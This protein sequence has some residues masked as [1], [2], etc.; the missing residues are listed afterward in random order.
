MPIS[1]LKTRQ[2]KPLYWLIALSIPVLFFV[3]IELGLRIVDYG[4]D[5]PLFIANPANTEYILP[6]PDIVRRYF[7]DNSP[8]PSVTMEANFLLKEKP[9]N[10]YRV[11]VQG[12]S[13]AAGFPYGL[14]ASLAGMLDNRLKSTLPYHYVEVVNT[15][16]SAV[17][18]YTVLDLADEIIAQQPDAVLIY[19]GHNE[20]LGIMG[21]GSNYTAA[22]SQAS[23]LL[24]LKLKELRLF[25]LMQNTYSYFQQPKAT[26]KTNF[27]DSRTFMAKVAKHK[28]IPINS[29]MFEAG[30][31]QFDTNLRLLL[32][33]YAAANVPVYL[34][35]IASNLKDQA[36]FASPDL[37]DDF[38]RNLSL[39]DQLI[40]AK[41]E[42]KI[43]AQ[44]SKMSQ[45]KS[46]NN[47]ALAQFELANRYYL[48]GN[49]SSAYYHYNQ[50]KELDLLRFRAPE[51]INNIIRKYA[52]SQQNVTLVDVVERLAKSSKHGLIGNNL[53]LEHL[54]PNVQ[55]YFLLADT[56]YNAI[57]QHSKLL[58]WNT[59]RIEKAWQNR[60]II[61][62]E[63]YNGFAKILQLM[64][65]FPFTDTPKNLTLPQPQ[66]W[67]QSLGK[68][69]FL[70]QI[71]W[72][73]MMKRALKGYQQE[74]NAEMVLKSTQLLADAMPHDP[75][76]NQMIG[77]L[78]RNKRQPHLSIH[79]YLRAHKVN[80][81]SKILARSLI[82]AYQANKQ[83]ELA[84][85]WQLQLDKLE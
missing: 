14:G 85:Q 75:I 80:P 41:Q 65:D 51:A 1:P 47:N 20:Y 44:L 81:D 36:P 29:N 72:V 26:E 54:H 2:N 35:T 66:D 70:K 46:L 34:A 57:K 13:T 38:S 55:G 59:V 11:F 42:D 73:T 15:A 50:A 83:P 68:E 22:S 25:Q 77:N 52:K 16:L 78:F 32:D 37:S 5:L 61:P 10:G 7:S 33:K 17:N 9:K 63:E 48:M 79:Y 84:R 18:S 43:T 49:F 4:R 23:T 45:A 28:N 6:R 74:K 71:D 21:V 62:S 69:Y 53:M 58:D 24:F 56:F 39:L 40:Q 60:P 27:K 82:A 8:I 30:V 76:F 64:G 12:G 3:L 19:M 67:Q 31:Q